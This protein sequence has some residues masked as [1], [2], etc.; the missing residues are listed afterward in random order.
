MRVERLILMLLAVTGPLAAGTAFAAEPRIGVVN[1]AQ[2]L[3]QS[4]QA[5]Q[6]TE[7]MKK[8]FA[9]RQKE[10]M[11][12]QQQI[13]NLQNQIKRNGVVMSAAQLQELQKKLDKLEQAYGRKQSDYLDDFNSQRNEKLGELQRDI[14]KA[15]QEFAKSQNYNLI[16]GEGVF[17]ADRT[18]DV[19]DQVL[20]QLRKDFQ[21]AQAKGASG[22]N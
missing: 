15:V 5:Q 10:L 1:M 9:G 12:E 2:L 14:L 4:P 8:K 17:Y 21:A 7:E 20:A 13:E 11:A 19:T 3:Q 6:A 18:V 16:I 22:G